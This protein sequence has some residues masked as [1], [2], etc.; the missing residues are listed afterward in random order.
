MAP[1]E[2]P[3]M[4]TLCSCRDFQHSEAGLVVFLPLILSFTLLQKE[5]T[6]I[7]ATLHEELC[8]TEDGG[9]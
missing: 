8:R 4:V 1:T 5:N 6:H 2:P 7:T 3:G 9:P